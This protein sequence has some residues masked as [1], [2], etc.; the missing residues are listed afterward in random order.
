MQCVMCHNCTFELRHIRHWSLSP[1]PT[2][3]FLTSAILPPFALLTPVW[4]CM[5]SLATNAIIS[6]RNGTG[7]DTFDN[8]N[9][10]VPQ[11]M[12]K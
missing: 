1:H 8:V 5:H 6:V 2:P 12:C 4:R 10:Q 7:F 9:T 3:R 11:G